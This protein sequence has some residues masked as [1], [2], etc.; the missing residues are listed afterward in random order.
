MYACFLSKEQD[1]TKIHRCT[2]N[3][4][5]EAT[6]CILGA[7]YELIYNEQLSLWQIQN[8]CYEP[9]IARSLVSFPS[10]NRQLLDTQQA[11]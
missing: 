3:F 6:W 8:Y 5:L 2:E 11:V 4:E 7:A 1:D 9:N 10:L